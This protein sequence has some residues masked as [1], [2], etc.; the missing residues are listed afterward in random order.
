MTSKVCSQRLSMFHLMHLVSQRRQPEHEI[1]GSSHVKRFVIGQYLKTFLSC[2]DSSDISCD[3]PTDNDKVML[4]FN[5]S[6]SLS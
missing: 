3:A 4:C 5:N 2:L 6:I 1:S